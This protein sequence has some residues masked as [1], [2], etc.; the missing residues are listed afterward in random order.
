MEMDFFGRSKFWHW[1]ECKNQY[2]RTHVASQRGCQEQ[3]FV[4]VSAVGSFSYSL[5]LLKDEGVVEP[6]GCSVPDEYAY[7]PV[8][9]TS[10]GTVRA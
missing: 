8:S 3:T 5:G 2:G 9:D 7:V 1:S 10:S 6:D 4:S